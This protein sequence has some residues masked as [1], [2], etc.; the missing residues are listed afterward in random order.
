MFEEA[1]RDTGIALFFVIALA[2][3]V[4]LGTV[5]IA[6]GTAIGLSQK[7]ATASRGPAAMAASDSSRAQLYF[8]LGSAQL[9]HDAL[10]RV[11]PLVLAAKGE[12]RF[13]VSGFHD[14]SGDASANA[15]LAKQRAIA[16]RDLLVAAGAPAERVVLEKPALTQGSADPR[17]AR[18]V[19]VTVR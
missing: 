10:T 5:G 1:D 8:E 15:E 14:A 6:T 17:E 19:E 18:R 13:A 16:V 12:A 3:V 2:I 11:A 7:P 9:P 4:A